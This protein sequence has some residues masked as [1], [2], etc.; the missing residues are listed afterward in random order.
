M[1]PDEQT[2]G[3]VV[4]ERLAP[5]GLTRLFG[6][7]GAGRA[8]VLI[9]AGLLVTG[10]CAL[11]VLTPAPPVT[12][13]L[14]FIVAV[15]LVASEFGTR[16][17]LLCA[18]TT[19]AAMS[20]IVLAGLA[21]DGIETIVGRS[22][23]VL[24]IAPVVGRAG[25]RAGRMRRLLEQLLD[26]S[27][28]SIYVKDPDGRYL[29]VNGAAARLI[30]RPAREIVGRA[31]DELLPDVADRVAAHDSAVLDSQRPSAY[32]IAGRFGER[33]YVL[34]V[35][36]S[37]FRDAA[38]ASIGSLG[39]ARDI[40]QQRRE[41]EESTRFFDLSGDMLCTVDFDGRIHRVNGE[42][43]KCLGWTPDELLGAPVA[44]F[45]PAE[46]HEALSA[47]AREARVAGAPGGRITNRWR[48]KDGSWH[49]IDWSLR[50]VVDDRMIYASGRDVTQ[51]RLAERALAASESRYRALVG[52]LPGTAV[53]LVDAEL[54]VEFAVGEPLYDGAI[55]PAQLIGEH[56]GGVLPDPDCAAVAG[57]C[58]AAHRGEGRSLDIVS[59][60]HGYALWLRTSPLRGER[61]RI[62]GVM[63]IVQDVRARVE[64]DREMSEAQERFRRAFE[65]APIGMAVSALNGRFLDVN[66]ALCTI[67]GYTQEQLT[68]TTFSEITHPDDIDA[69]FIVMWRLISGEATSSVDEKRYLRPDGS[70]VWVARSVTLVR[71]AD[72]EPLHFLDQIQD[73]TERRRFEHELR[74]LADHDPLTGLLNRRRFEQ[75]LDRHV[76]DVARYGPRG[77]LL[78][79]DLDHFKYVNDALGHHAGDEL[80][81]SVA[82]LLQA[83][84]RETDTL[85]RLG[86]DEFAVLLPHA[87]PEDA[88][89]VAAALVRTV[90]E[91][92][93]VITGDRPRRVTTSVGIAPFGDNGL[94]GEQL[95]IEA[96]LAMYEA[97]ESGRDRFAV[98]SHDTVMPGR[99]RGRASWLDRVRAALDDDRFVLHAQPIRDLRGSGEIAQHELL[100]RMV[101]DEGELI[102]PGTFLPLAERLG[103]APEIDRW[104]AGR[105]IELL[106]SDPGGN[107]AL[108]VNLFGPSLNDTALLHLIEAELRS[109]NIDPRRLIFEITETAAVSN[110][111]LA[112]R[113]AE[114]LTGLGC[115]FALDDFGAG[116]GSFYYLKHL[117]FDYLKIDGEFVSGC[118][119]NRTDQLVIEAVVRIA[120]G[121]GKETIAEFVSDERLEAFVR[122][123][124]VD[125][126]QGYY[127]GRPVPVAELGLGRPAAGVS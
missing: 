39:I 75:E 87:G 48:A 17:G 24:F 109:S 100:L 33:R 64:R 50:T 74:R 25:E 110:I 16:A 88:A 122:A 10:A 117:P 92:A 22:L 15:T 11:R 115:R 53:F 47:A 114:R 83:R 81:L 45:V 79:L 70:I 29:L 32:E 125:H 123:Q 44:D 80:I 82:K 7:Y 111:P 90:R 59:A 49:W 9:A 35:T 26:A 62:V 27:T 18:L 116:F 78:V 2:G 105:A 76:A 52:G 21:E 65:D 120:R 95:L 14:G 112:R 54:R 108:E 71:D 91:E 38:G 103:L 3:T 23:V 121:L 93:T 126:A 73:V 12:L 41:Q 56:V 98:A 63:L 8:F 61:D 86:G 102:A 97:K 69:D 118:L 34:S 28:D 43:Q 68:G 20:A 37:P 1:G 58:A 19:I 42:W 31:N 67:T 4:D 30:G 94:T 72:G 40:T 124:G 107:V 99:I 96:D 36:K 127:V 51:A 6:S 55:A 106:A 66:Q 84:L 13:G 46:D 77:A 85:A 119:G 89:R 101:G 57:A 113:F 60:E 5:T 104:V